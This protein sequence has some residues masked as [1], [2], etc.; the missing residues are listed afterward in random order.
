MKAIQKGGRPP[1]RML[2]AAESQE[3]RNRLKK[4]R[5]QHKASISSSISSLDPFT[6]LNEMPGIT[7]ESPQKDHCDLKPRVSSK[8][9]KKVIRTILAPPAAPPSIKP[10]V[11]VH[12]QEP[13]SNLA[14][15][16]S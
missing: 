13:S 9:K 6:A 7:P 15:T 12:H 5:V 4:M 16:Y 11:K 8:G 14:L 1:K 10:K 3:D 2:G